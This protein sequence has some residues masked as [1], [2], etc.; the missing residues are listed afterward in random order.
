MLQRAD[1][2]RLLVEHF[3]WARRAMRRQCLR[4]RM[5]REAA[6]DFE[7]WALL[8]LVENDY[9]ILRLFRGES[10][11]R[12]YLT[13]VIRTL[14]REFRADHWGRYRPS[15]VARHA[16]EAGLELDRLMRRD[17]FSANEA[18]MS[19]L[20]RD[21]CAASEQELRRLALSLPARNAEHRHR[22]LE[23]GHEAV[24]PHGA[25][26]R[27]RLLEAHHRRVVA[28]RTLA[29][30]A[31]DFSEL[32]IE[33]LRMRFKEA[34]SVAD[35]SR[36]LDVPQKPLYRTLNRLLRTLRHRLEEHGITRRDL[37]DLLHEH[38]A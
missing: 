29:R 35:I 10:S 2:E 32:E 4:Y 23:A 1:C 28:R 36:E 3:D 7:S 14:H 5:P 25:D 12:T 22:R 20:S 26:D 9:R 33:L 8:R 24:A 34:M 16:G 13:V 6:D 31:Q 27:V 30:V 17:R 38:A 19:V 11:L 37:V 18:V 21:R 15:A